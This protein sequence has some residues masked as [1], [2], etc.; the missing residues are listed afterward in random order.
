VG[1]E[2]MTSKAAEIYWKIKSVQLRCELDVSV[3][4]PP[5]IEDS[6]RQHIEAVTA[7]EAADAMAQPPVS[8]ASSSDSTVLMPSDDEEAPVLDVDSTS[9]LMPHVRT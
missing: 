3:P 4:L 1:T 6:I 7:E 8:I 2:M 9:V 5:C